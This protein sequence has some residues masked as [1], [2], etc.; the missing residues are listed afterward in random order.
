MSSQW[1]KSWQELQDQYLEAMKIMT[2]PSSP[3]MSQLFN[4]PGFPGTGFFA[5]PPSN[6]PGQ[7]PGLSDFVR[8]CHYWGRFAQQF[9]ALMQ[10]MAAAGEAGEEWQ[11]LLDRQLGM[12]KSTLSARPETQE[13]DDFSQMVNEQLE[14]W[15]NS[16]AAFS[17]PGQ[18]PGEMKDPFNLEPFLQAFG[19]MDKAG[20]RASPGPWQDYQQKFT[21]YQQLLQSIDMESLDRL[22]DKILQMASQGETIS[23]AREIFRLWVDSHEEVWTRHICTE[24]YSKLYGEITNSLVMLQKSYQEWLTTMSA[25][26]VADVTG[27]NSELENLREQQQRDRE[28]IAALEKELA[29]AR[30][31]TEVKSVKKPAPTGKKRKTVKKKAK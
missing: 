31:K 19:N 18:V 9:Q 22:R 8:S 2:S 17:P 10:A 28:K 1:E 16:F 27:L 7:A 6:S 3:G 24:E 4:N 12:I 14:S 15:R 13:R 21:Q 11:E 26:G 30:R 5:P 23:G 20:F 29:A 25:A